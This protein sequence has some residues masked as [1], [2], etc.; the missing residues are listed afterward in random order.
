MIEGYPSSML[1]VSP[2]LS[3][4]WFTHCDARDNRRLVAIKT[5]FAR[6]FDEI[7]TNSEDR[8][9]LQHADEITKLYPISKTWLTNWH[10][11]NLAQHPSNMVQ[12]LLRAP[13]IIGKPKTK[14]G[15]HEQRVSEGVASSENHARAGDRRIG[16]RSINRSTT[17]GRELASM[18]AR[19]QHT[20][21]GPG[22][23]FRL[24]LPWQGPWKGLT[25]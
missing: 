23:N 2:S 16:G 1:A 25:Q 8:S 19:T 18:A 4:Q 14:T 11:S 12:G 3:G 7:L 17:G 13:R 24:A 15:L 9:L 21:P 22:A 6:S 10:T 20:P 5:A